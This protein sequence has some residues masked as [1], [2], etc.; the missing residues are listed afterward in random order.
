MRLKIDELEAIAK[1]RDDSSTCFRR[2]SENCT[3]SQY[4]TRREQWRNAEFAAGDEFSPRTV[5]SSP[6]RCIYPVGALSINY[7]AE[8]LP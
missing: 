8:T 5:A 4:Q 6:S 2:G 3:R 1:A 7:G